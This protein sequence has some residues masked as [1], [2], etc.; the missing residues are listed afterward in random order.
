MVS[1]QINWALKALGVIT[2]KVTRIEI[3]TLGTSFTKLVRARMMNTKLAREYEDA[4]CVYEK[5]RERE[6]REQ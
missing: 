3:E 2:N 1:L 5:N 4:M 6:R